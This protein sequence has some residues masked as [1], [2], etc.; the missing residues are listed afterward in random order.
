MNP[1]TYLEFDN[2]IDNQ[3][4]ETE[5][6][7][8]E[9]KLINDNELNEAF[10][11][12]K[13]TSS[14]LAHKF[15]KETI[16]FKENLKAISATHFR[17]SETKNAKV[18]AFKP[19]YYAMAASVAVLIGIWMF[20]ATTP[21]NFNEYNQFEEANFVERGSVTT[22]LKNAQK[23]FNEKEYKKAIPLFEKIMNK[24]STPEIEYYYAIALLQE[25]DYQTSETVL[26]NLQFGKSIY[27]SKAIWWL[28]LSNLKQNKIKECKAYLKIVPK[29]AEDYEKAQELLD[30]L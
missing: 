11:N 21:P 14:F 13:E 3:M 25:N 22:T 26:N 28:A 15:S 17:E 12:Y 29:D 1:E 9:N 6:N 24:K 30:E 23:A 10:L 7:R 4:S 20:N 8:F 18:I 2:Y 27:A 5:R 16:D 19:W